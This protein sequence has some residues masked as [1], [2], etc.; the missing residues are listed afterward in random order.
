MATHRPSPSIRTIAGVLVA[1]ASALSLVGCVGEPPEVTVD[2]PEL[3]AG[4]AI[5]GANCASCHSANGGGGLGTKLN[6]GSV[7]AAF[8]EIEDQ[9]TL[10]A[11]GR[12]R[13]PAFVG[14][15][16]DEELRAVVRYTRE[17]L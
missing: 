7:V 11:D 15:L 10:V 8:P 1:I 6:E 5:Y 16:T 4:R 13:M 17:V 12:D 9:I 3:V 14:R 2:D